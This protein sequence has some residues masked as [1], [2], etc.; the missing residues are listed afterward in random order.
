MHSFS[1]ISFAFC[2]WR[3]VSKEEQCAEAGCPKALWQRTVLLKYV[4][5]SS[6]SRE[7]FVFWSILS[8][9]FAKAA[10]Q[11]ESESENFWSRGRR[12]ISR[13]T[14]SRTN[15]VKWPI[16]IRLGSLWS[17]KEWSNFHRVALS[18][19][20]VLRRALCL[21][22]NCIWVKMILRISPRSSKNSL[23]FFYGWEIHKSPRTD[24]GFFTREI[25]RV[26]CA[27]S[28]R[29]K[30]DFLTWDPHKEEQGT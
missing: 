5:I 12:I 22:G 8:S 3:C 29:R 15:Q 21:M 23:S 18:S 1:C 2:F 4:A 30:Q 25:T 7:F 16:G 14:C 10:Y 13:D 20:V 28:L 24:F 19:D 26:A 17:E 6:F 27:G 9:I 11:W